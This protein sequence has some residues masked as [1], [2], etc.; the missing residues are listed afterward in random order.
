MHALAGA[1]DTLHTQLSRPAPPPNAGRSHTLSQD[2]FDALAGPIGVDRF[3]EVP[4]IDW[5][6]F[7][8][9]DE[10]LRHLTSKWIK[11]SEFIGV[12]IEE[13]PDVDG[14]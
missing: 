8:A 11:S 2:D 5:S 7:D 12:S 4:G 13:V 1:S 10:H 9:V 6:M 3:D 14:L